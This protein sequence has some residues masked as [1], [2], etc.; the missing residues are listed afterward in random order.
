MGAASAGLDVAGDFLMGA[1]VDVGI[2]FER[3]QQIAA[4]HAKR[5]PAKRNAAVV[6]EGADA[7]D[8]GG[9]PLTPQRMGRA[10]PPP[11]PPPPP[12]RGGGGGRPPPPPSRR[13][14][15]C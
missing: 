11:P 7:G 2:P 9:L 15:G 10:P 1:E 13:G 14:A 5:L 6:V 12:P 4:R 8:G 3:R